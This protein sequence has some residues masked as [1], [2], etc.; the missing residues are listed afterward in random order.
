MLPEGVPLLGAT[1]YPNLFV[2]T[3]QGSA[4]W[5]MA[6]GSGKLLADMISGRR[7]EIDTDGLTLT[8]YGDRM[9]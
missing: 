8:R 9:R 1:R 5:A 2:N 4:S 7:A 3:G 6:A